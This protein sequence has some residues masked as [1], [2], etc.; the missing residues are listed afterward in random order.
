MYNN[1]IMSDNIKNLQ[2][3]PPHTHPL[4]LDSGNTVKQFIKSAAKDFNKKAVAVTDH[5]TLGAI[6]E[7]HDYSKELKKKENLDIKIIPGIELYLLPSPDDSSGWS[8][9]HVTVHFN[10]FD[11]YLEGS[12]LSKTAYDRAVFKGG[13]LK[14]LTTWEE[15]ESLS[16]K[17]TLFSGCLVSA[18]VRPIL[19]GHRD[20]AEKNFVRLMNIAGP[21]KFFSEIFPYEVS[22]NWDGKKKEFVP[23]KPD[24]CHDGRLQVEA[25]KW[26]M[27]LSKKYNVP[28][29]ISEDAH[30]AHEDEKVIQDMRLG[31]NK[32]SN[33]KMADANC[34][35]ENEW[36]LNELCKLH[37][38]DVNEYKF[39]Q[40]A[41]N[42]LKFLETFKGF[43]PQFSPRLPE[44]KIDNPRNLKSEDLHAS[45]I[46]T[47]IKEKGRINFNDKT[48]TARLN[49]EIKQLVYNG[50]VDLSRYML[51]LTKIVDWCKDNNVLVGPGRGSAAGSL[52]A[53]GLG[54]TSVDPIKE[55]LSFE[56]FFDVTR[57]EEGLADIDM[58]FSDRNKVVD[59]LKEEY[60]DKFAFLGIG[61]TFKT[62][63][64]LKDIDRFLHG[65]VRKET[66]DVCKTI[67]NSPQGIAEEDFL[68]GY[69]D[70]DG[71]THEGHLEINEKLRDYLKNNPIVAKYLFKTVGIIR[72]MG[73]HAAGIL[74][75]DKPIN[76]FIPVMKVSGEP[77]TQL[78][79]KFVEKS[80]GIKY[81]ILGVSTLEDIRL[82]LNLIKERHGVDLDPWK[83][84]DSDDF[85]EAMH[86]DPSTVFQLHTQTVRHGLITMKPKTVQDGAIL[87][88]VFRPGAMDAP[89]DEDPTKVM[90][91]IFLE[92]WTGKREVKYIHPELEFILK[93]TVG[94]IV[95]QEQLM[96]IANEL[97]GLSMPETNKLR[98]AISKK[99]G[100][101]LLVLLK[102]VKE[103]LINRGWTEDQSDKIIDQM[104]AA[105]KYAFNKSHAISY[106]YIARACAY[107]KYHYPIEWWSAILTN[108]SKDDLKV[109]WQNMAKIILPPD[110][111]ESSNEFKIVKTK[112]GD[113]ILSPLNLIEK[114]GPA[115]LSEIINKRPYNSFDEFLTKVNRR[116]INKGIV[117]RLI[118]SGILDNFFDKEMAIQDKFNVFLNKKAQLDGKKNTDPLPDEYRNITPLKRALLSKT[119]FKVHNE[120]MLDIAR[121]KLK[122]L[123]LLDNNDNYKFDYFKDPDSGKSYIL[124]DY[125]EYE[126][127]LNESHDVEHEFAIVGY[128][129]SLK[130]HK[131]ANNSKT[132]LKMQIDFEDK[133]FE[134]IKWP[135]YG[136]NNHG[137]S[138]ELE[139][140]ISL[141]ILKK[142]A[143]AEEAFVQ[144]VFPLET[145][146]FLKEKDDTVIEKK[147]R[148]KNVKST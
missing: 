7:A 77:T 110:I 97:G 36:L 109:Y 6:I 75:A 80:G 1:F 50:K 113:K 8:Y 147:G 17:V 102:K 48:Y 68:K 60:K 18:A 105:G 27:Y 62:K 14:P 56:R 95:F 20:I 146:S 71:N 72:Q 64:V 127:R 125:D 28:M 111:N 25:N 29:V 92:R 15:L 63:T 32:S 70:A 89:S 21:G 49:N 39:E 66:E 121:P 145:I 108:A 47:L 57:V 119:I 88:S 78:L 33:W 9:Y 69:T 31:Q 40:M 37:P 76:E 128:I 79:P 24:S 85:W 96:K 41:E 34:L 83:L 46:L 54:I 4:S 51:F 12:K 26:I 148:K 135:D 116:V 87:T 52:L 120:N 30:Y 136:K 61:G 124:I 35:H 137:I 67:P 94:V 73:R 117:L 118:F 100:D 122:S 93:P 16:G 2:I 132:M 133:N 44:I 19:N 131:Y 130:E 81:D 134:L 98:K 22:K 65:E 86:E 45:H 91:D 107:L 143:G 38:G 23:I 43:E 84:E 10:D 129:V 103:G 140:S 138:L 90:S 126:Y 144:K 13:E 11:A 82:A 142:R 141:M 101:E 55:D 115:V 99:S 104:K 42:S 53:Y 74:I 106:T 112:D 139:N 59:Y 123:G 3:I 58:D 114:V 5:G